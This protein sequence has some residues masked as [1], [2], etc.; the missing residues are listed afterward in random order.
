[1]KVSIIKFHGAD[2][3]EVGNLLYSDE[4]FTESFIE[5]GGAKL[6]FDV[7]INKLL[8]DNDASEVLTQ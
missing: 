8:T 2:P 3:N 4:P 6:L 1:M 5:T 7:C